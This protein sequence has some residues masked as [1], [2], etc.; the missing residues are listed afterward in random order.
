MTINTLFEVAEMNRTL[1]VRG[2][3]GKQQAVPGRQQFQA[4]GYAA[5]EV[6]RSLVSG[7]G[8]IE[9]VLGQFDDAL[10]EVMK[11]LK[12]SALR[13]S[14]E[15]PI[16]ISFPKEIPARSVKLFYSIGKQGLSN[17]TSLLGDLGG[18]NGTISKNVEPLI[19]LNLVERQKRE[20]VTGKRNWAYVYQMTKRGQK[21]Y[22]EIFNEKPNLYY[23]YK[24]DSERF[25]HHL[26]T[27]VVA[28]TLP[29]FEP[30]GFYF[31]HDGRYTEKT[32]NHR[33]KSTIKPDTAGYQGTK[34]TFI[35]LE[36]GSD[37]FSFGETMKKYLLSDVT[38]LLIVPMSRLFFSNYVKMANNTCVEGEPP[39]DEPLEVFAATLQDLVDGFMPE[40]V[41]VR[42]RR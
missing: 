18:V 22:S 7:G 15:R 34:M 10:G 38:R 11:Q 41:V 36:S 30:F 1:Q 14:V 13:N 32:S 42:N 35:E 4:L 16:K 8:N 20:P 12:A 31:G 23:E 19:V 17:S 28:Y 3:I 25:K 9:C 29:D 37:Y 26:A 24:S 5:N 33:I 39:T 2:G 21:T 27:N 6:N 40:L